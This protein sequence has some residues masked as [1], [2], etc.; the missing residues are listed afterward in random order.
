MCEE[1]EAVRSTGSY[2]QLLTMYQY[3]GVG[4]YGWLHGPWRFDHDHICSG[5]GGDNL[6][7]LCGMLEQPFLILTPVNT[8]GH[9]CERLQAISALFLH[10]PSSKK[11]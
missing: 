1:R 4:S 10:C 8:R 5:T 6:P 2:H 3:I 7:S 11:K 9:Y